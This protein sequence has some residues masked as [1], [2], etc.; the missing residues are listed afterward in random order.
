M[1]E[2]YFKEFYVCGL[3]G[4]DGNHQS[5]IMKSTLPPTL[6]AFTKSTVSEKNTKASY[7][8][9]VTIPS[10][11]SRHFYLMQFRDFRSMTVASAW[12]TD[13]SPTDQSI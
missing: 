5:A 10:R 8:N 4:L 11:I 13:Q 7:G 6:S 12:Q 3:K 9:N 2:K 1:F